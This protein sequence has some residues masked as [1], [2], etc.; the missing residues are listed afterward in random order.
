MGVAG[1]QLVAR[2]AVEEDL[3][4]DRRDMTIQERT[5]RGSPWVHEVPDRNSSDEAEAG[6]HRA[7]RHRCP[8][9]PLRCSSLVDG[10]AVEDGREVFSRFP[11]EP[12]SRT[13]SLS[14]SDIIPPIDE[15]SRPPHR[16]IPTVT[17]ATSRR[18][19]ALSNR[20]RKSSGSADPGSLSR[21]VQ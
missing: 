4:P 7:C 11:I 18:S 16:H 9:G 20:A 12:A 2:L 10:V 5:G 15:E 3:T 14:S 1:K 21:G 13:C 17:S 19:T 6:L 8:R